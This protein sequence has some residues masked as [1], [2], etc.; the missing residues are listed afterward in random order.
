MKLLTLFLI[1]LINILCGCS[2]KKLTII[3]IPLI[4]NHSESEFNG[5]IYNVT[6]QYFVLENYKDC[7]ESD[8]IIFRYADSCKNKF[9]SS[10][11]R[12]TA[13]F[14]K[15]TSSTSQKNIN[16]QGKHIDRYFEYADLVY[17]Y[18]YSTYNNL[19]FKTKYKNGKAVGGNK[20]SIQDVKQ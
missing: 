14:Y 9:I 16:K 10:H 8:S 12:Y 1:S 18:S 20:I 11:S 3:P 6:I 4:E 13:F 7:V 19:V 2:L 17:N 15:Q 5:N